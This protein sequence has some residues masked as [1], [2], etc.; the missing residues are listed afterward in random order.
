MVDDKLYELF[1][2][3]KYR[4]ISDEKD[5]EI[6]EGLSYIRNETEEITA[7]F[8]SEDRDELY[9]IVDAGDVIDPSELCE[10]IDNKILTFV[11]FGCKDKQAVSKFKYNIVQ[12][13][14]HTQEK[15]KREVEN[16]LD[17]S[18]KILIYTSDD[19]DKDNS[20]E[21]YKLPFYL[22]AGS[23]CGISDKE[24]NS[25]TDIMPPKDECS[26]LYEHEDTVKNEEFDDKT[27]R[28]RKW[29][30]I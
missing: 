9:F 29:L 18:R 26:F 4:R 1:E 12:V 21:Y 11:N 2:S 25:L 14:M 16:S 15:V 10:N 6:Y 7:I 19:K 24:R 22:L 3:G 17:I 23:S 30:N 13:V 27:R 28:I 5:I 8:I 20:S